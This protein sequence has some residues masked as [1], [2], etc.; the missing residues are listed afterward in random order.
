MGCRIDDVQ[1]GRTD[2]SMAVTYEES[3]AITAS[4]VQ[5]NQR[6]P[7]AWCLRE[8]RDVVAQP[9]GYRPWLVPR[10]LFD[11]IGALG[12]NRLFEKAI[13]SKLQIGDHFAHAGAD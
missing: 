8:R 1:V 4:G 13:E 5:R 11:C 9:S 7:L 12:K 6:L 10:Q 3:R 2:I